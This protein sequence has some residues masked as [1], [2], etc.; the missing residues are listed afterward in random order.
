MR[1]CRRRPWCVPS[2]SCD[3]EERPPSAQQGGGCFFM[4]LDARQRASDILE[5]FDDERTLEAGTF[6]FL[7]I[8]SWTTSQPDSAEAT[9]LGPREGCA[10]AGVG[11]DDGRSIDDPA[12]AKSPT[13]EARP[14]ISLK[15]RSSWSSCRTSCSRVLLCPDP[16]LVLPPEWGGLPLVRPH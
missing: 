7:S 10:G 11:T 4:E 1:K 13:D 8:T 14:P 15:R 16:S 3:V 6:L 9:E 5:D 2:P 12:K